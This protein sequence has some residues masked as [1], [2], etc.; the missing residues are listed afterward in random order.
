[1]VS[2]MQAVLL[3]RGLDPSD[4]HADP[5]VPG[6]HHSQQTTASTS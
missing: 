5:F 6:D 3:G 4:L 1:M 2:A